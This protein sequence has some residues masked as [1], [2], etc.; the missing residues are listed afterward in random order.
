MHADAIPARRR[1]LR[2][3]GRLTLAGAGALIAAPVTLAQTPAAALPPVHA[4]TGE[5]VF[6]IECELAPTMSLGTGPLGERRMV[7]ITGGKFVGPGI[8]G[9]VLPGG[10]DRQLVRSDGFKQLEATYELRTDDGAILSI[11][12]RVLIPAQRV[13]GQPIF[14]QMT[15]VA[16][17]GRYGWLNDSVYVGTLDSLQPQRAAVL[18]RVFR[19]T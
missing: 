15:V 9:T 14:S 7:P 3:T 10:A 18:I 11:V 5:L 1:F 12:N 17:Q 19:L 2:A 4:P 16:P 8:A 6:Q 13:P